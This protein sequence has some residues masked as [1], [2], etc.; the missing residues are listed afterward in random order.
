MPV[1]YG[2]LKSYH[3]S[4]RD[5]WCRVS[6]GYW[7]GEIES[8]LSLLLRVSLIRLVRSYPNREL[9]CKCMVFDSSMSFLASRLG[10]LRLFLVNLGM[11]LTNYDKVGL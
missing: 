11:G 9:R 8:E 2:C 1:F 3:L 4:R 5:F 10:G 6:Q 7:T